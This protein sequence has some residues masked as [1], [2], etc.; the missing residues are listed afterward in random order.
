MLTAESE[1][2][3]LQVRHSIAKNGSMTQMISHV[4]VERVEMIL[5]AKPTWLFS[6][7]A[8]LYDAKCD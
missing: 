6:M 1:T 2:I 8:V 4:T 5:L 3:F 7:V